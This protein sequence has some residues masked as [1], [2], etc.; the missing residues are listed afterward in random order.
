MLSIH[1]NLSSLIAQSSLSQSTNKLNQAIERMSTGYKINHAG[2]NA[3]NYSIVNNMSTQLNSYEV[4]QDNVGMGMDLLATAQ[5]S[6]SLMQEHGSRIHALI[7]QGL[8]GTY[9]ADSQAA[10]C[11]EINARIAEIDRLYNITEYNG[12]SLFNTPSFEVPDNLPQASNNE[13]IDSSVNRKEYSDS[14]VAAMTSVSSVTGAY[15]SGTKYKISTVEEL[16]KLATDINAGKSH[17]GAIFVLAED[18]NLSSVD[19]WTP[20]GD[21]NKSSARFKGTFNGNGHTITNLRIDAPEQS[22]VGLFGFATGATVKNVDLRNV[23]INGKDCSGGLIGQANSGC[24]VSNCSVTGSVS[25]KSTVGGLIGRVITNNTITNCWVDCNVSGVTF[26]GG[27]SG[28][29]SLNTTMSKCYAEG[30]IYGEDEVT[31]GLVGIFKAGTSTMSDCFSRC[32]VSGNERTGGLC[33]EVG[34]GETNNA[35]LS[36]NNCASYSTVQSNA[37]SCGSFIGGVRAKTTYPPD[38]SGSHGSSYSYSLSLSLSNCTSGQ[39]TGY[40]LIGDAY[41]REQNNSGGYEYVTDSTYD[42]S[43]LLSN[44]TALDYMDTSTSLQIG[45]YSDESSRITFNTNFTYSLSN[46]VTN[47]TVN[48]NA[49]NVIDNFLNSLSQKSTEFGAVQN[50]LESALES[51]TVAIDNLT[52]SR[53]TLRDADIAQVSSQYIQQQ[54]LQ[55]AASTLLATANQSPSIALQLI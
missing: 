46:I 18:L 8:N 38:Y 35:T 30:S 52:S 9:G 1:T 28:F 27:I 25:G 41:V 42:L 36:I 20:I 40:D 53:S 16:E 12:V 31:G 49:Y 48:Q 15:T 19:N 22:N 29:V 39:N 11:S 13:F 5:D 47:K 6:I 2:D 17:T 7:T 51:A 50:R 23:S 14:E 37:E 26:I 44:V 34:C 54:I 32:K 45:I 24:N 21:N 55:Q 3:A 10:I 43:S 33:G 4:A